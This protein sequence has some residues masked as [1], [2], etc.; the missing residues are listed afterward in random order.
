[1]RLSARDITRVALF[2]SLICIASLIL[3][4]GG[5]V[6]VPFSIL[7]FMVMLAGSVLGARLGTLS[8]AVYVLI[9]LLGVPVFAKPP[10]GGLA[11]I[12]QPTAGFLLGFIA[13]AYIIGRL[14]E[15]GQGGSVV[16]Y[17]GAMLA[18]IGVMYLI[19]IPYLYGMVR[20]YLGQPFTFWKTVQVGMLPFIGLDVVKGL[21]AA[22]L[23]RG[24]NLRLSRQ[25]LVGS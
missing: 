8:V 18:G 22:V 10:F 7:P 1:M 23:A 13:M 3:K 21:I 4:M 15:K 16:R 14:M 11:Y 24:I 6:I 25:G 9:G 20:L 17:M 19:G 12:L 2:S 5:D